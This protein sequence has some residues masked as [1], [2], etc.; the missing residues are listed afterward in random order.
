MIQLYDYQWEAIRNMKIYRQPKTD[1][2]IWI[3]TEADRSATTIL[4]TEEY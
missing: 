4:F 3:I 1:I 2:T